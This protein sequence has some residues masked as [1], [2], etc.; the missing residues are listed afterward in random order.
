ML[1]LIGGSGGGGGSGGVNGWSLPG[2]GGGGGGGALML[3]STGAV[4]LSGV[5]NAS[6]GAAGNI[7]NNVCNH[8]NK[9]SGGAGGGG[10]GGAV[11]ILAP[12]FTGSGSINVNGGAGGCR[13]GVTDG[14]P[15][16]YNSGGYGAVGRS[17]IE[18][19]TGGTFS[20]SVIPSLTISS[21]GGVP[22]PPNPT[23]AG[24]V[25]LPT[26]L[27]N[28]VAV[29]VAASGIPTG[30][31]VKLTLHAPYTDKVQADTTALAGTLQASTASGNISIPAGSSVLM[32][33]TSYTLSV[34]MGNALK[35]YAG[36]E[37]VEKIELAAVLGAEMKVTLI[38]VSGKQ[39]E[40][41]AAVLAMV[42][43]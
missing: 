15:N 2:S 16:S 7:S 22:V 12:S 11:R 30:S 24:D 6:G 40:V 17:S 28:P 19:V 20:P 27:P 18:I 37:R 42:A 13:V 9:D 38:T 43:A 21:I 14:Y 4:S 25:N 3:V 23:G 35:T 29:S 41:P 31:I 36:G 8:G 39:Y 34:A 10:A 1:P 32:A 5:I 26:E 33:S